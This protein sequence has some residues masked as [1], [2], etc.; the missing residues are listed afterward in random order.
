LDTVTVKNAGPEGQSSACRWVEISVELG[1]HLQDALANFLMELGAGG[2]VTDGARSAPCSGT[3]PLNKGEYCRVTA[4]LKDDG[5]FRSHIDSL[6]RYLDALAD[7]HGLTDVPQVELTPIR[8]QDW[9]T[10]WQKLFSTC[11]IGRRMVIKPTWEQYARR[12]DDVVIAMDPGMAFGTGTHPT[13]RMCLE[14]IEDLVSRSAPP[15]RSMLD[16][17]TGSGILSIAAAKLGIERIVGIDTDPVA[18]STAGKNAAANGVAHRVEI[19]DCPL[20]RIRGHF[21]LI[22][23]NILSETLLQLRTDLRRRLGGRGILILSGILA[24]D[25]HRLETAFSSKKYRLLDSAI[26]GEWACLVLQKLL[27]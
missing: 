5:A 2:V 24:D 4:Y 6:H 22:A 14:V 3:S 15:I 10:Q 18:V 9:S 25:A 23:A 8:E 21:D 7:I 16:I 11:R 13:T 19:C 12:P 1:R 17:G 20:E 26:Q 27:A